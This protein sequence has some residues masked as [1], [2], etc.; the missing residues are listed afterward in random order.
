MQV[1]PSAALHREVKCADRV[2]TGAPSASPSPDNSTA[3]GSSN[4]ASLTPGVEKLGVKSLANRA[5]IGPDLE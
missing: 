3:A 5:G 1:V 2:S 4:N